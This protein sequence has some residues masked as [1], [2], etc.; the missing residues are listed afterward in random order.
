MHINTLADKLRAVLPSPIWE[1]LRKVSNAILGPI[2]FSIE[3]GHLRSCFRSRA[4][5]RHGNPLPWFTYPAIQ[6]LLMKNFAGRSVLEWGAGQSTLFWAQRASS[7]TS[8]EEDPNWYSELLKKLPSNASLHLTK[9][10]LSNADVV[11]KGRQFDIIVCDG[12]DRFL[13]AERS[14]PLLKSDGAIIIDNS[15]GNQGPRPGFGFIELYRE[16]GLSRIDFY[17]YPPGNTVQQCTSIFFRNS[18]FLFSG[19][20][21]PWPPLSFWVYPPEIAASWQNPSVESK[22]K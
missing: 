22:V 13:C 20:E 21:R 11:L 5:D 1:A 17:G 8:M 12:L 4:V 2:H 15:D 19:T 18:C 16:S 7:V 3:T 10:D 9:R 6:F 14:I